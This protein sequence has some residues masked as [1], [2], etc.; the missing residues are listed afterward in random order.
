VTEVTAIY[1]LICSTKSL[2]WRV[3]AAEI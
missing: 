2:G 3:A 1:H